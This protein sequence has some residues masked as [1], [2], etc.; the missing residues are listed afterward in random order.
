MAGIIAA[1]MR[2]HRGAA[3]AHP[4]EWPH[5]PGDGTR[6]LVQYHFR[7]GYALP[8]IANFAARRVG[9]LS[10][11]QRQP[12]SL[13]YS[14]SHVERARNTPDGGGGRCAVPVELLQLSERRR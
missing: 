9:A 1:A 3:L 13:Q 12:L 8:A 7:P 2:Q 14:V 5:A 6:R 4:P 10:G 11:D